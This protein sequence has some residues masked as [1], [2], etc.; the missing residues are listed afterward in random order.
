MSWKYNIQLINNEYY[1][2]DTDI[3]VPNP[4]YNG[5]T[6]NIKHGKVECDCPKG[7]N[8]TH[9]EESKSYK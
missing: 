8:G 9:C 7:Y 3:C 6:C 2:Y 5:G 4:C 1:Q